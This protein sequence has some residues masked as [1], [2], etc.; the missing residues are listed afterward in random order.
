MGTSETII[1]L[2]IVLG[3]LLLR[4]ALSREKPMRYRRKAVLAGSD[5]EFFRRLQHALPGCLIC[6]QIG[7][8]ALIEPTGIGQAR[9]DAQA[10]IDGKRIG[11]TVFD[12]DMQ[13]VAV[14][15]LDHHSRIKRADA[16]RDACFA[17]LGINA[18]RFNARHLPSEEN[19]RRRVFVRSRPHA[20]EANK[21]AAHADA[22]I[23]FE[24]PTMPWRDTANAHI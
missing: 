15:E 2:V 21:L 6:P 24:Q 10:L 20:R 18:L 19:I 11:Y 13:V 23:D 12:E 17:A 5:L 14:I 3:G 8:A 4:F 16:A 22:G 9:Q 1:V 7:M